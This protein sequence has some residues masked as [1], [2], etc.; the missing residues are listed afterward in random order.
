MKR[1]DPLNLAGWALIAAVTA[2][3]AVL[4]LATLTAWVT[5]ETEQ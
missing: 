2:A 3:V 1:P 5:R 4:G